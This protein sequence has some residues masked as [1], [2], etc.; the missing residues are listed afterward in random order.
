M[1]L[2]R[3]PI[4]PLPP[5]YQPP[6]STPYRVKDGDRWETVAKQFNVPVSELIKFNFHTNNTDEVNW[7]LKRNVGCNTS[8]DGMNWSFSA[9]ASPGVIYIP[10]QVMNFEDEHEIVGT[11]SSSPFAKEFESPSSP[12][13]T[14]GK[15]FDIFQLLDIGLTIAGISLGE[16]AM[17]GA[18]IVIAPIAPFVALGAPHEAA[19]NKLRQDQMVEGLTLGIVLGADHRSADWIKSHNFVKL[20]PVENTVYPEYG[21]DFQRHYNTSLVAGLGHGRQFNTVAR[22]NM[23]QFAWHHMSGYIKSD[24]LGD[25]PLSGK[26]LEAYSKTWGDRKWELYYRAIAAVLRPKI[27]MR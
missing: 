5:D 3:A 17:L 2:E 18:G 27:I 16:V 24:Y 22:H 10:I 15:A 6:R 1:P 13:D 19:L 20:W 9:G 7:Y 23:F 4:R 26:E 21:K 12:L 8:R 25:P 11:V 14:L